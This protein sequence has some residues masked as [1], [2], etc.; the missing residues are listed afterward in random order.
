VERVGPDEILPELRD[1][2]EYHDRWTQ[3][4]TEKP[5]A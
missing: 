1:V 5:L 3:A 4:T 2:V